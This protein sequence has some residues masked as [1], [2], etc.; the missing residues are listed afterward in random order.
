MQAPLGIGGQ[1]LAFQGALTGRFTGLDA[2]NFGLDELPMELPQA[3]TIA[4]MASAEGFSVNWYAG[5]DWYV[6][7]VDVRVRRAA[8][9]TGESEV[10][11][12]LLRLTSGAR[13]HRRGS[14]SWRRARSRQVGLSSN[15]YSG[16]LRSR[17]T[18]S[19]CTGAWACRTVVA[20]PGAVGIRQLAT[21]C[22]SPDPPARPDSSPSA[23]RR[24][25]ERT[26]RRPPFV[27]R[28]ALGGCEYSTGQERAERS[29]SSRPVAAGPRSRQT[30]RR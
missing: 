22:W 17:S 27:C 18:S 21:S 2:D 25:T 14:S 26:R 28:Q 20:A 8:T 15:W 30:V 9:V 11:T 16:V 10:T 4:L 19:A 24:P 5:L 12:S 3:T 13:P 1:Y 23:A 6:D 29:V 7:Q